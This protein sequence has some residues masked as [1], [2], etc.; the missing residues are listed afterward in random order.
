MHNETFLAENKK[1]VEII[2]AETYITAV[3]NGFIEFDNEEQDISAQLTFDCMPDY[4]PDPGVHHIIAVNMGSK[5]N[6]IWVELVE[7]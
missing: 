5:G 4:F 1:K 2:S 6:I 3:H 7:I